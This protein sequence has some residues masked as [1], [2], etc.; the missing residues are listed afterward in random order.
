MN[1]TEQLMKEPAHYYPQS[2][3]EFIGNPL[4]EALL[5]LDDPALY[6]RLLLVQPPYKPDDRES[7]AA[8]RLFCL[9]RLSELHIPTREDIMLLLSINRSLRWGYAGRNPMGLDVVREALHERGAEMTEELEKY[10]KS[11]IAPIY[12][13]PV[14]GI[15]GVGKTT[16]VQNALSLF[17]QVISHKSYRGKPFEKE[18]LVWLKV[19]CPGD[20]T[21]KGLCSAILRGIDEAMGTDYAQQIIRN[22]MSKDVLLVKVSQLVQSLYLGILV[23]DDIQ[24]ICSTKRTISDELLSFMVSMANNLKIPVVMVGSPKILDLLQKEFQQAKRASGEGEIR[25]NLMPDNSTEWKRF[26]KVLWHYQYTN[27]RVNL[28]SKMEKT[29]YEESVGNPFVAATLY[30]LVQDDAI[31]SKNETFTSEDVKR[32]ARDKM[33]I[34]AKMRKDMLDGIDVELNR[35]KHL[36]SI[37]RMAETDQPKVSKTPPKTDEPYSQKMVQLSSKLEEAGIDMMRSRSYARQAIAAYPEEEDINVLFGYAME[38]QKAGD[39]K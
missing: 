9:Q 17:P 3:E 39:Q 8:L 15:S 34:T 38:L 16:S 32:V 23:I 20:G 29:F 6:P 14:L 22:R 21:P 31:I 35:Y 13:F 19:D 36:W 25:M 4:L 30:K 26:I 1:E 5:P 37:G 24:N 7:P 12:G 10:L 18:Q 33:G 28:T 11:I 2:M 27:K